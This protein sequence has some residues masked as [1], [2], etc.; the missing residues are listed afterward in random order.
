VECVIVSLKTILWLSVLLLLA[1]SGAFYWKFETDYSF[2]YSL[3][4]GSRNMRS[5]SSEPYDIA[6]RTSEK[7]NID[8]AEGVPPKEWLL[9]MPRNYVVSET[10]T[11]GAVRKSELLDTDQNKIDADNRYYS[12]SLYATVSQDGK[13]FTPRDQKARGPLAVRSIKFHLINDQALRPIAQDDLCVPQNRRTDILE[14]R[15]FNGARNEPCDTP[16]CEIRT[17]MSGWDVRLSVTKDLFSS[18]DSAC[19]IAR[20]F[21]ELHTIRRDDLN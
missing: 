14:P 5:Q 7:S 4:R 9:R 2:R 16:F 8:F 12:V 17:H 21:L 1:L 6:L 20:G 18:P 3:T 19:A 15:G 11:N 13:I 10:G